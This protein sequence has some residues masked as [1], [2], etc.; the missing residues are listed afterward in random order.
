MK[1]WLFIRDL[2]S[3]QDIDLCLP[4]TEEKLKEKLKNGHEYI[5]LDNDFSDAEISLNISEHENIQEINSFL[6]ECQENLIDNDIIVIVNR[7]TSDFEEMKSVIENNSYI[8]VSPA[9]VSWDVDMTSDYDKGLLLFSCGFVNLPFTYEPEM[10]NYIRWDGI[11]TD[12]SCSG[13]VHERTANGDYL[14][15]M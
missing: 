12:A 4:M 1:L 14:V 7:N 10:E 9:D 11:W 8:M 5:I 2:T 13:W 15:K 6:N 3:D